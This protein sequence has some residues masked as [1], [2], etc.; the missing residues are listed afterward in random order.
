[1][2]LQ[3][4]ES[5][6]VPRWARA[7]D[8]L[9]LLLVAVAGI[10]A[11]SGGFRERVAGVRVAVTSPYPPL[12]WALII[13]VV[14]HI[15]APQSPIYR[16]FPARI[17]GWW[18]LRQVRSAGQVVAWTRPAILLVGYLSVFMIGYVNGRAPLRHFNNELLNLPVRWDAGWYLNIVTDGYR[19][20]PDDDERQQNIVFF[21]A[22]PMLVRLVGRLFGGHMAGYVTA[23]MAVSLAAFFGALIYLYLFTRDTLGDDKARFAQW[24]I[25]S[26]PFALFFGAIYTESLFLLAAIGA[27]YHATKQQFGR[28]ALWGLLVGL[29]KLNGAVLAV[30]LFIIAISP[31]IPP[32]LLRRRGDLPLIAEAPEVRDRRHVLKALLTAAAPGFGLALYASFI[33][34]M[35]GDPLAWGK[36]QIAWGRTYEPIT[37]LV[38]NQY[39]F[40]ANAG[41]SGYLAS[42]GYDVLNTLAALFVLATVWPVARRIGLAYAVLI[43]IVTLPPVFNG[44]WLSAGRFS[45]VLFPTFVWLAD[46][47][48]TAHRPGWIVGFAA[49]QAFNAALFYTWR[50]LI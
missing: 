25:A 20:V 24:L 44:G 46:V 15:A 6:P 36:G 43:L 2:S 34:R 32:A 47:I 3:T 18:Q 42:P 45:S 14:R 5:P 38:A 4:Y 8:V 23:G 22:Y 13:G 17:G 49:L 27:F 39:A 31:W 11:M 35:T 28:A 37:T 29:T 33:W 7:L 30:P 40:I 26:Y 41:L 50:P 1:M 16:E 10:V 21:P 12:V 19:Y 48:P 9:C